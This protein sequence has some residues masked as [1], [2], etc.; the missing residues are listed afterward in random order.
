[1]TNPTWPGKKCIWGRQFRCPYS[2]TEVQ[3]WHG[4]GA[5]RLFGD[6][7]CCLSD[8]SCEPI[9]VTE[10]MKTESR[11]QL[12]NTTLLKTQ[13]F[14]RNALPIQASLSWKGR[15]A[16]T[17][18]PGE[19]RPF[20]GQ[21]DPAPELVWRLFKFVS[22][23]C[24]L[25]MLA[26]GEVILVFPHVFWAKGLNSF[27]QG[28]FQNYPGAGFRLAYILGFGNGTLDMTQEKNR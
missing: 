8:T 23:L 16:H 3:V 10:F 2:E 12:Y 21:L 18:R 17:T 7:F 14:A 28:C 15:L 27:D 13:S 4:A 19:S 9:A 20:L 26:C 6:Y 5:V 11:R 1:M 24:L 22:H 25:C